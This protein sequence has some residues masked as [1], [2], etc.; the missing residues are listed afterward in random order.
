MMCLIFWFISFSQDH[1]NVEQLLAPANVDSKALLNYAYE[2]ASFSTGH[3][4]PNLEFVKNYKGEA[5][6]AM[7]DFTCMHRA[8]NSCMVMERRGKK[9]LIG[10]VGDCLVEV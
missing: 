1:A 3:K 5:D 6:T 9:L 10:L 2:A 7:F 8:E 4:L